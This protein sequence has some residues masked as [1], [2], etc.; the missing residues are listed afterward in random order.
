LNSRKVI[1]IYLTNDGTPTELN[2]IFQ[3]TKFKNSEQLLKNEVN[4]GTLS[5]VTNLLP[6]GAG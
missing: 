4:F 1:V 5:A 2:T 3:I 6:G